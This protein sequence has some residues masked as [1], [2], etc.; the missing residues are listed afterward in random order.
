M[1][2]KGHLY[3]DGAERG[4]LADFQERYGKRRGRDIY[5]AVVGK[6]RRERGA[7]HKRRSR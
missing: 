6:V 3:R 5:F 7:G 2:S 4:E 1:S